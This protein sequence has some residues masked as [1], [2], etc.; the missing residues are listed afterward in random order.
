MSESFKSLLE[1]AWIE[2]LLMSVEN[3]E[4]NEE[5]IEDRI[6]LVNDEIFNINL[7]HKQIKMDIYA[8]KI[9]R[10]NIK[11]TIAIDEQTKLIKKHAARYKNETYQNYLIN[12]LIKY[13]N[14]VEDLKS[15]KDI[16]SVDK[17]RL[18]NAIILKDIEIEEMTSSYESISDE[19]KALKS[20]YSHKKT[21]KK[22]SSST[23]ISTQM[24]EK[25]SNFEAS[26]IQNSSFLLNFTASLST[27]SSR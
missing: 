3:E 6:S 1:D 24:R 8:L 11:R 7:E 5:L 10:A 22:L 14:L 25:N 15:A 17:L 16:A 27:N 20:A 13:S 12:E 26:K 2:E 23:I 19:L 4:F 9:E 21:S 18:Q